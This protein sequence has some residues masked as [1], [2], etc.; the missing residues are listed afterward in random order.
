[1]F[2]LVGGGTCGFLIDFMETRKQG[3]HHDT[4]Q[5]TTGWDSNLDRMQ[6]G[7]NPLYMG[8]QLSHVDPMNV[9]VFLFNTLK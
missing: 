4:Q 8:Q 9:F 1:M 2:V 3:G 5:R 7:L 6:H